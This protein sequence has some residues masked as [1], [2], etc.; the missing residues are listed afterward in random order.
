MNESGIP[1]RELFS[2]GVIK[3]ISEL[4]VVVDDVDLELGK[5]RLEKK[6]FR[7]RSQRFIKSLI[8]HLGTNEFARL[9]IGVG[10][11]PEGD[12]LVDYVLWEI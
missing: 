5:V 3:D 8:S 4:L 12:E 7:L 1:V 2:K 6:R 10:P 11:R 9:R